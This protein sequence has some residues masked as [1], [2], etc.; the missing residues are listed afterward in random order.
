[1]IPIHSVTRSKSSFWTFFCF[2]FFVCFNLYGINQQFS[3]FYSMKTLFNF[4]KLWIACVKD[5]NFVA[6][7]RG[8][9]NLSVCISFKTCSNSSLCKFKWCRL[10]PVVWLTLQSLLALIFWDSSQK[11]LDFLENIHLF[12]KKADIKY[13]WTQEQHQKF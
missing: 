7:W 5:I 1:M 9:K 3:D 10:E 4:K 11:N 2:F 8:E 12:K 13:Y 6:R